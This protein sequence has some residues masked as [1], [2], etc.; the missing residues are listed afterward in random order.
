V[1]ICAIGRRQL[2]HL[3]RIIRLND[4]DAFVIVSDAKEVM[5]LGFKNLG[6]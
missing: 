5:G 6:A 1:L 2:S 3:K 4:P